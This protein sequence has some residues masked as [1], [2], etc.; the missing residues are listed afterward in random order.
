M[1]HQH[2]DVICDIKR[3]KNSKT[4]RQQSAAISL[5]K[6]QPVEDH[7]TS[8]AKIC[9]C[10][11]LLQKILPPSLVAYDNKYLTVSKSGIWAQLRLSGSQSLTRLQSRCWQ[12][13][14][15]LAGRSSTSKFAH[16]VDRP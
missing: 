5:T 2:N 9:L 15:G 10:Y 14:Q 3:R 7:C 1:V 4:D 11:L 16:V 6:K 13:S 8:R 12:S